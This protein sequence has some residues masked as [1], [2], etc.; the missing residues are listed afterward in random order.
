MQDI[1]PLSKV[2]SFG[3]PVNPPKPAKVVEMKIVFVR[4]G[5]V[6]VDGYQGHVRAGV[7]ETLLDRIALTLIGEGVAAPVSKAV[8]PSMTPD[9][10]GRF[11]I[12]NPADDNGPNWSA[13]RNDP[14]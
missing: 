2:K 8:T 5:F 14:S 11:A 6:S 7:E 12:R 4:T 13:E 1:T 10:A 9:A 3:G